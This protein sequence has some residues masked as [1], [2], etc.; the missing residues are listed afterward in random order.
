MF[1]KVNFPYFKPPTVQFQTISPKTR[2]PSTKT[3]DPEIYKALD[4]FQKTNN[5]QI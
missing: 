2:F 3:S 5:I 4:E 1:H